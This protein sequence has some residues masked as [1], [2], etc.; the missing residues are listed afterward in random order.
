MKLLSFFLFF[1]SILCFSQN[2]ISGIVKNSETGKP[3]PFANITSNDSIATITD[4]DGKFILQTSI[5][6]TEILVSYIGFT[7]KRIKRDHTKKLY[8]ILVEP[9]TEQ[10]KTVEIVNPAID[11][12]KNVI[13]K[14]PDNNPE[15]KLKSFQFK[16]YNKLVITANP[17]SISGKLDSVFIDR[18]N[19]KFFVKIDSTDYKFKKII[20][21]QHI[22][23]T[24]KISQFQFNN[25]G[26]KETVLASKMA[27]FKQPIYELIGVKLQS[28]SIYDNRYELFETKYDGPVAKNALSIYDFKILDTISIENRDTYMIYF[29]NKRKSKKAGLEG[30]LYIDQ[31]NYAIAKAILRVKSVLD[32]TAIHEYEY[33]TEEDLWFPIKRTFKIVKGNNDEDVRILGGNIKFEAQDKEDI[34]SNK[35]DASD[36]IYLLSQ[37]F[38]F[39]PEYNVPITIKRPAI[40]IEIKEQAILQDDSYWN[41]YREENLDERSKRTYIALDSI[42]QKEKI[43]KKIK[44]GR[45][46]LNGYLP[47][48]FFDFDLRYLL[49]YNNYEGFRLGLGGVTNDKFSSKY[50]IESYGAYGIK[51]N[52]FKYNLGGAARLGKFSNTWIG[53]SYTDDV[54]EIGSTTFAIDKRVFRLYDPRPINVSTFYNH[55]TWNGFIETKIIP[56]TESIWQLTR[57]EIEPKFNYLYNLNG[58]LYDHFVMTTAMVSIQWNP[59]SDFMQTPSGKIEIEKRFPKFTFQYTQSLPKLLDNDFSF[60]KID[61]RAEYEKKYLNGQKTSL[62]ISAGYAFGD[63]PL[64]HLYSTSPNNLDK[65]GILKRITITG[66]NSFETM[67]FNEFF[68]NKYA[69]LQLKHGFKRVK[70]TSGIKPSMVLVTRFGWGNLDKPE[71]HIGI[72]YKTLD[73]GFIESGMELNQIYKGFGLS[74]FYR[75]GPN[76]LS[77]FDQ[78]VSIKLTY[79][80][81]FGF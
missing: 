57:N 65:D 26:F 3:L 8:I 24:E 16:A 27:G 70:I 21:K 63:I 30:I 13:H 9:I 18:K 71:Q 61:F 75:Y 42:M 17:D 38:Y 67:Y 25:Q 56:K 73:D 50:R 41:I 43:E 10:L 64:T 39:D 69:F 29:K 14:K 15:K 32:I 4:I 23:Q 5:N 20:D 49:K 78:N 11:I 62:L 19:K 66:K 34:T 74:G 48:S 59:F 79:I 60:G 77:K 45:R 40:A 22:Y 58:K 46:I 36:F 2:Q 47:V 51:D 6:T 55:K 68:S 31:K 12:L 52:A 33:L 81:S 72:D 44:I 53:G 37:S 35:K 80:F 76:Q 1:Y 54:S 28:H 7:T